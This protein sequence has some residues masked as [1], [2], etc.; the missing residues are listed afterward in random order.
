M[1][2]MSVALAAGCEKP[3]P[4]AP[5]PPAAA[6]NRPAAWPPTYLDHAQ[7]RLTTI[8]LWV[9]TAELDAEVAVSLTEV[10]TGMMFRTNLTDR[11][12]MLFLFASPGPRSFY[13][14]NC[15]VPLSAAYIDA[16]GVIDQII[17]LEPGVEEPV[18]SRS[19]QIKYVLEVPRGWFGRN[20]VKTGMAIN[21]SR[22]PLRKL[23]GLLN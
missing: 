1:A 15:V 21:T 5:T 9:G 2:V 20:Q 4:S 11:E 23:R 6:T 18:P 14:K 10:S 19:D 3:A 13:M 8:K 12:G 16:E 7:P 22:G 17:D